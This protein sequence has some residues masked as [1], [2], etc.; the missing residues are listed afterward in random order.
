MVLYVTRS[1]NIIENLA[2]LG[3]PIRGKVVAERGGH[4]MHAGLMSKLLPVRSA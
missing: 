3:M 1:S 2:L 4:I